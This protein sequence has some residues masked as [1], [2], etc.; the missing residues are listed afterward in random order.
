M[1]KLKSTLLSCVCL[2]LSPLLTQCA[3][4]SGG[5]GVSSGTGGSPNMGGPSQAE[6][7]ASIASEPTGPFLYGR[8]Y[9][10]Y[11]TR[12]WGYLREPRQSASKAK[13]VIFDESSKR[14]PDRLPENGPS[15]ARYGFDNNFEYKISGNYTGQTAYEPNS[16]QFLP[17]FRLTNYQLIEKNPGWLFTPNDH[18]DQG[19]F[20]L[21]P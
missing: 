15:G 13:L 14:N 5:T 9:F 10:V 2:S 12:F 17:V 20:T 7:S 3:S 19:T 21:R 18:Y 4:S 16:N 6:R 8:R 11:K 1:V